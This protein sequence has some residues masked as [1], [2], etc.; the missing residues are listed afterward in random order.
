MIGPVAEDPVA[1]DADSDGFVGM[2]AH[3]LIGHLAGDHGVLGGHGFGNEPV[4][5]IMPGKG[6]G[7]GACLGK[8]KN[9]VG[10]YEDVA[11]GRI[12]KPWPVSKVEWG[13]GVFF[14]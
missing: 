10:W 5:I 13:I 14:S 11:G 1:H 2:G 9:G 6:V 4:G 8:V 7:D 12:V 3:S